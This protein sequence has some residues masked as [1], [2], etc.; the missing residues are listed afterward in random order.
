[1]STSIN[2]NTPKKELI[3]LKLDFTKGFDTSEHNTILLMM[4]H[5]GFSEVWI[6]R[7]L[8][9]GT[10]LICLNGVPG[11]HFHCRHGVRQGNPLSPLLFVL[12]ADQQS[13]S[14]GSV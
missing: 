6:E 13:L 7:I 2:A 11:N 8:A 4:K 10:S 5:L 3:I 9:S 14:V 12:A 1:M